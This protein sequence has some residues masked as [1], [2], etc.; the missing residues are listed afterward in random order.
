[1]K[2]LH[3]TT[4]FTLAQPNLNQNDVTHDDTNALYA[5]NQAVPL[6]SNP[7][8]PIPYIGQPP[9]LMA[10][11]YTNPYH[12]SMLYAG[13]FRGHCKKCG[14]YGHKASDCLIPGSSPSLQLQTTVANAFPAPTA[15]SSTK[16]HTNSSKN[17][18]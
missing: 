9:H 4:A 6:Y 11:T 16:S 7:P 10:N 17:V 13:G 2:E 12:E 3:P 14:M 5:G 18:R 8:P 15:P 1:M